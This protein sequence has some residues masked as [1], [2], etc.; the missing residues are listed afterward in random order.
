MSQKIDSV[1][2]KIFIAEDAIRRATDNLGHY[3]S[4]ARTNWEYVRIQTDIAIK[5]LEF[6]ATIAELEAGNVLPDSP[7]SLI[8]RILFRDK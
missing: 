2:A 8:Q 6:A 4:D 1:R 3:A 5:A 7:A